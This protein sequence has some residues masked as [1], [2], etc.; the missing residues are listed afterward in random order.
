M[1]LRDHFV[2]WEWNIDGDALEKATAAILW[3]VYSYMRWLPSYEIAAMIFII[4]MGSLIVHAI[5]AIK[6]SYS[7][8]RRKHLKRERIVHVYVTPRKLYWICTTSLSA[9]LDP[10]FPLQRRSNYIAKLSTTLTRFQGGNCWSSSSFNIRYWKLLLKSN[11]EYYYWTLKIEICS[12]SIFNISGCGES[13]S[14][15]WILTSV[16]MSDIFIEWNWNTW[17]CTS[18]QHTWYMC[19]VDI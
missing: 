5:A 13:I 18:A 12:A 2:I 16:N 1:Y 19:H 14:G 10:G 11:I 7:K 8:I 4:V 3:P 17:T 15:R 9:N 6:R